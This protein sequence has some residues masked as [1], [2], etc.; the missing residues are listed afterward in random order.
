MKMRGIEINKPTS[1][2]AAQPSRPSLDVSGRK[3][4]ETALA[5][6]PLLPD[7]VVARFSGPPA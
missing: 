3:F 1:T 4:P 7:G 5:D 6:I 2:G